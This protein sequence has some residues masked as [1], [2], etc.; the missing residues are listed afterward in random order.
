MTEKYTKIRRGRLVL[1]SIL[2]FV[3]IAAVA[4]AFL[5]EPLIV[6]FAPIKN[7]VILEAGSADF[8][9]DLYKENEKSQLELLS[10]VSSIDFNKVGE[11]KL[12]ILAGR[13]TCEVTLRIVDTTPPAAEAVSKQIYTFETVAAEDLVTNVSDVSS[14]RIDFVEDPAFGVVGTQAV[15]LDLTDAVGN[16]TTVEAEL[17]IIKDSVPPAFAEMEDLV[18]RIGDTISYKK[19]VSVTDNRDETVDFSVDSSGVDTGKMGTYTVTYTATDSDDNTTVVTRNVIIQDKLVIDQ[20]LVD[21]LAKKVLDEIITESMTAHE[22]I[23]VIFKWVKKNMTYTSSPESDIVNAAYVAFTKK[24]GDCYNYYSMTKLLLD[25]CGIENMMI[26]R[27]GGSTTHFWSLVNVGTGWYHYD[28]TPQHS[29]YPFSCFMKTDEE[30][31]AYANSRGDG[32]TDYYDFDQT[33][34]P[35]RATEKYAG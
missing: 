13:R 34:Y 32:R 5:L 8:S 14:V 4:V 12:L 22:K 7:E 1:I 31:W 23:E 26:E 33:L 21:S 17:S 27:S 19:G 20:E 11:H 24:R 15:L 29:K 10:D 9:V 35:E 16:K 6:L 28:T 2:I 18:V 3:L 30:V 25:G